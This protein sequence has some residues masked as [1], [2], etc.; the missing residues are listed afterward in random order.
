MIPAASSFG[1][2]VA[3]AFGWGTANHLGLTLI[4]LLLGR[5]HGT[6]RGAVLALNRAVSY[7][8]AL[9]GAALFGAV[10]DQGRLRPIAM[11]AAA[12]L[13]G[14]LAVA[15][16]ARAGRAEPPAQAIVRRQTPGG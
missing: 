3:V 2:L 10:Y 5:A 14:A 12:C 11:L 9:V 7:A 15:M 13:T 1:T 8:G 6:R 16:A 4:V